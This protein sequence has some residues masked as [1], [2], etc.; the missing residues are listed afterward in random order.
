MVLFFDTSCLIR[1]DPTF[2]GAVSPYR[3]SVLCG[4]FLTCVFID[5]FALSVYPYQELSL[6]VDVVL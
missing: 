4:F 2:V 6:V 5:A 1:L 3:F